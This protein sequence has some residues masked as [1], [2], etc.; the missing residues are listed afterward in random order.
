[1]TDNLNNQPEAFVIGRTAG[2]NWK[3][4]QRYGEGGDA[5]AILALLLAIEEDVDFVG[6]IPGKDGAEGERFNFNILDLNTTP[7]AE[8]GKKDTPRITARN[9]AVASQLF[10]LG[11]AD[12]AFMSRFRRALLCANYINTQLSGIEGE[13]NHALARAAIDI[14][15]RKRSRSGVDVMIA[16]LTVPAFMLF[17]PK[18]PEHALNE[19]QIKFWEH[20]RYMACEL[21]GSALAGVKKVNQSLTAL[22]TRADV[23]INKR[24][25]GRNNKP[26]PVV[27]FRASVAM[28]A[29]NVGEMLKEDGEPKV[30]LSPSMRLELFLLQQRLASL[31][32]ADPLSEEEQEALKKAQV[33]SEAAAQR[34][35]AAA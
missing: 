7:V 33:Q 29:T 3:D 12:N 2:S 10:G 1:M 8:N 32:A 28:I 27:S 22:R 17:D 13:A 26:D 31:F 35:A 18:S 11:E 6:V 23:V 19:Q 14:V 15:Q 20:A 9:N 5:R 25:T 4:A 16:F 34:N 24:G 21:D 30:A